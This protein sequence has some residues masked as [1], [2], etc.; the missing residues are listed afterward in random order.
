MVNV[1]R[2]EIIVKKAMIIIAKV[3]FLLSLVLFNYLQLLQRLIRMSEF[4]RK[5]FVNFPCQLPLSQGHANK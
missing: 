5:P 4:R 2:Q 3:P 1:W